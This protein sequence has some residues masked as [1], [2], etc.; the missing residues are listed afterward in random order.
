MR[1]FIWLAILILALGC[2]GTLSNGGSPAPPPGPGPRTSLS[3]RVLLPG[4]GVA[5]R[6]EVILVTAEIVDPNTRD[7]GSLSGFKVIRSGSASTSAGQRFTEI[8]L[9]DV[10]PG[11]WVL[12]VFGQDSEGTKV[13]HAEP[14]SLQ[15]QAGAAVSLELQ[16][17]PGAGDIPEV[18]PTPS[19]TQSATP[20]A[21]PTG[22]PQPAS[23]NLNP[24]SAILDV[25]ATQ[26][27]DAVVTLDD[28]TTDTAVAWTTD[29]PTIASVD[30]A[31][32][33]SALSPGTAHITASAANGV[34]GQATITVN[35]PQLLLNPSLVLDP[36]GVGSGTLTAT[37]NGVSPA[38][39]VVFHWSTPARFG[40]LTGGPGLLNDFDS[41]SNQ[42][43][44]DA[45]NT[46]SGQETVTVEAFDVTGG[47][48]ISLGSS[49]VP[50]TVQPNIALANG[51]FSGALTGWTSTVV[52][53]SVPPGFPIF[54]TSNFDCVGRGANP[55][56]DLDLA[57]GA[58]GFLE[59]RFTIP[60]GHTQLQYT[61]WGG[62]DPVTAKIQVVSDDGDFT[63]LQE[64]TLTPTITQTGFGCVVGAVTQTR[65]L[66][67]VPLQTIRL[68]L[69]GFSDPVTFNSVKMR[70]D[71]VQ[72]LP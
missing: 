51:D 65:T 57:H 71:D 20:T 33:V 49:S 23:V 26:Q 52:T 29:A 64:D 11:P 3:L 48:R 22:T 14:F 17:Q 36:A 13:A 7:S 8:S 37:L 28:G 62:L 9:P 15:A 41:T 12:Y 10:P 44:Y 70:V 31:G 56:F 63:V 66:P 61:I 45:G 1:S 34:S 25:G 53:V 35:S 59:Q 42:A 5:A 50:V 47:G 46:F 40:Q 32:L 54:S 24:P 58:E 69:R 60:A 43:T 21:T 27:L 6:G 4:E 67:V 39:P 30:A 19:P 72:T 18:T 2:G 55:Y 68:R 38:V 16:L